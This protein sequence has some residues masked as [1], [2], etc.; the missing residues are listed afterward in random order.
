M[1]SRLCISASLY[2]MGE[3]EDAEGKYSQNILIG[4]SL[5]ILTYLLIVF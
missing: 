3:D 4:L 1:V 2:N 5:H